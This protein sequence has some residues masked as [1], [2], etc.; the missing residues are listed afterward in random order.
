MFSW[1]LLRSLSNKTNTSIVDFFSFIWCPKVHF[2][3]DCHQIRC[4]CPFVVFDLMILWTGIWAWQLKPR[5]AFQF[6]IIRCCRSLHLSLS[7]PACTVSTLLVTKLAMR[8]LSN[9]GCSKLRALFFLSS[10]PIMAQHT[11]ERKERERSIIKN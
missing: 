2:F 11:S 5:P 3:L 6:P 1:F 4:F 9:L 7:Q 8:G 10:T